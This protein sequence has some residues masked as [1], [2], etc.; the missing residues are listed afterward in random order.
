MPVLALCRPV[1]A[2][3]MPVLQNNRKVAGYPRNQRRVRTNFRPL[4]VISP[5]KACYEPLF[6]K[7]SLF[8]SLETSSHMTAHT[9]TQSSR[10]AGTVVDR[11]E[12]VS[13]GILPPIFHI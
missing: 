1:F 4:T 10:T 2:H 9:T 12:A 13:A 8:L 7:N 6:S 5:P 3:Q 11:K